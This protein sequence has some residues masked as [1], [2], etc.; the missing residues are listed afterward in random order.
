[1]LSNF[2]KHGEWEMASIAGN[3]F[4]SRSSSKARELLAVRKLALESQK[5][6][7]VGLAWSGGREENTKLYKFAASAGI[8]PSTMQTKIRAMIRFGFIKEGKQCPL[9]WTR[10]GSLWNDLYTIGNYSAAEQIYELTLSISLAVFAFNNSPEQYS[11]NPAEGDMPLKFLLNNLDSKNSILLRE[12][13]A[14]VDGHT[15]REAGKNASYWKRDLINSGLFRED[16]DRLYYTGKYRGLVDE[17]KAFVPEPMLD[18]ADWNGIRDN[19]LIEVSP[20][21]DSIRD[22]FEQIAQEED[23]E[24]Q[25]ADEIITEPIVDIISEQEEASIPEIDILREDMRFR[26]ST[27]RVRNATWSIRIKK[28]YSYICAVP[29]CDVIGQIFV[30]A[31]HIKPDNIPDERVPHRGHILNGLCLC[32]HCHIAFDKG[33]F[34]LTDDYKIITSTKFRDIVDQNL[35]SVILSS[36]NIAIKNRVDKRMPLVDFIKYHRANRF[37]N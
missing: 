17:I 9:I 16:E 6:E 34:S 28:K 29:K 22:I 37:K 15:T 18:D 19:P 12:F 30:E 10:M 24:E 33:F 5:P 20:F 26:K 2:D 27:R 21:R 14:L 23:L 32:R 25:I 8:Q 31:A 35:K 13:R 1:V 4:H 7:Y 11:I 3:W 36:A